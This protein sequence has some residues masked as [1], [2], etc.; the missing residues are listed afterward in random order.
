MRIHLAPMF[1]A[2]VKAGIRE[3]LSKYL[4]KFH[5]S[6]CGII[7]SFSDIK[8]LQKC[9]TIRYDCPFIHF[10]IA[11]KVIS[12]SPVVGDTLS[13]EISFI[14]GVIVGG[15]VNKQSPEHIGL[16]VFG[17]FNASIPAEV[18]RKSMR[19]YGSA[20]T[21]DGNS[22]ENGTEIKFRVER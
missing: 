17:I 22:L 3:K 20:W 13:M 5:P 1:A 4:L 18:L 11:V 14:K 6:V 21:M 7:I 2:D 9:A 8:I 19:F 15:V 16:L 10:D 12:F